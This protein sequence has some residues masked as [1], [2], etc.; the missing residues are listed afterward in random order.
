M[1]VSADNIQIT[2]GSIT[3]TPL[4]L[5]LNSAD[6]V[7][8]PV[9]DNQTRIQTGLGGTQ[10][11]QKRLTNPYTLTIP[12]IIGSELYKTLV[13]VLESSDTPL[14]GSLT[15]ID[16]QHYVLEGITL[17]A[18]STSTT[19]DLKEEDSHKI[20]INIHNMRLT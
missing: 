8:Q 1:T 18:Y 6:L 17:Q 15:T 20:M 19:L 4:D 16:N 14:E 7:L 9:N 3:V 2:I 12:F 10:V 13:Y 5:P 11:T